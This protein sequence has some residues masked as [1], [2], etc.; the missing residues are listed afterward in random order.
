LTAS[1]WSIRGSISDRVAGRICGV[2]MPIH[3]S[4]CRVIGLRCF[5]GTSADLKDNWAI[6]TD[7]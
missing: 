4:A 1:K 5:A 7:L 2:K 3:S 6:K